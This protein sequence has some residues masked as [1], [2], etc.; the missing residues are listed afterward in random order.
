M[1]SP[2][3]R[4]VGER[5]LE[6]SAQCVRRIHTE[7]VAR[8][9]A[10]TQIRV[11]KGKVIELPNP[12]NPQKGSPLKA[13]PKTASTPPTRIPVSKHN[14]APKLKV[15]AGT[16]KIETN[17]KGASNF[18]KTRPVEKTRHIGIELE[19]DTE[20]II[21]SAQEW[22]SPAI[23]DE[24]TILQ[25]YESSLFPKQI[26]R[27]SNTYNRDTHPYSFLTEGLQIQAEFSYKDILIDGQFKVRAR[28][29]AKF[30]KFGDIVVGDGTDKVPSH[31]HPVQLT[32]NRTKP[33]QMH[34]S[35]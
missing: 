33:K 35:I 14:P 7:N 17:K 3:R 20:K 28:L 25:R 4:S 32:I 15:K 22:N 26:V 6:T 13:V 9:P 16:S 5:L 18:G 19:T 34:P 2:I 12:L 10:A 30:G 24:T 27:N 11:T 8:S 29:T 21:S 1:L 31:S 23:W